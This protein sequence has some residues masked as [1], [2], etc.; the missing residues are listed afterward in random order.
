[1]VLRI[2]DTDF[3]RNSEASLN[4]IY[5][6]LKWLNLGWDEFYRQSERL[7][8]HRALAYSLLEKGFA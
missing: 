3:D 5:D 1:M 2:D 7:E 8:L 4:S 6:G